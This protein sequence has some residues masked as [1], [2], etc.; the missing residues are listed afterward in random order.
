[1]R[2]EGD[3]GAALRLARL[4]RSERVEVL[5]YH[6]AH[7]V[8]LGTMATM[9]CG[10]RAAVA[11]RRVSFPLRGRLFG[12]IKYRYRIDKIVAVSD[13]IRRS[14]IAQG[15]DPR[16]VVTVHSGVDPDRFAAGNRRRFRT[17]LRVGGDRCPEEAFLIG[18]A[19]HLASHKGVDLFLRAAAEAILEIPNARFVIVG[20]GREAASLRRLTERLG[21]SNRVAFAGF[22]DDMPDVL[23][24][25]D[26]FVLASSSGEGSPAVLKEAMAAG[27]PVVATAIDGIEEIVEDGVHGL[28][29]PAEDAAAMARAVTLLARDQDLRSRLVAAGR[30]RVRQ[31]TIVRMV[32]ATEE[33]Y[34][35]L[36]GLGDK[37]EA[38]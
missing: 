22:R 2:G 14:L 33:V 34:R 31:F 11:A 23:A 15:L 28:F 13:A 7:A 17:A 35:S 32:L 4:I 10:R 37:V 12:R 3:V 20:T 5:H 27:V 30:F 8:T 16:R 18:T 26:A 38:P 9:F 6:T 24:G 21:I 25:L 36:E 1:M 29:T 19:T